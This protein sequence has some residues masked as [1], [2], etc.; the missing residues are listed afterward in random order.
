MMMYY[1]KSIMKAINDERKNQ[2]PTIEGEE[3]NFDNFR[4]E[5][6]FMELLLSDTGISHGWIKDLSK[7]FESAC[8]QS[9][10]RLNK[11]GVFET[12]NN[13]QS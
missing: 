9:G 11:K 8:D 4:V 12:F 1:K 5:Y 3:R 6:H 7:K 13:L 10:V 2:D